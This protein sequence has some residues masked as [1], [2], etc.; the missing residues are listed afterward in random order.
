LLFLYIFNIFYNNFNTLFD[1][2]LFDPIWKN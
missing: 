2:I 1:P